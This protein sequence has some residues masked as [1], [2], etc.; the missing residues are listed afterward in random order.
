MVDKIVNFI[1]GIFGASSG[2]MIGKYITV[3]VIS[4]MPILELRGGLIA[5]SLLKVP[6]VPAYIISIIGNLIPIPLI[7]WFLD[8]VFVF[9]KK[10]NILKKFVLFCERK[11]NEK[12][13][14]IEKYGFWGLVLF[15]GVPLPGTGAWTGCLIA[16]MLR[17]NKKKAFLATLLG[18]VMASIIMMLVS[19]GVL[20]NI[21]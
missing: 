18:V 21:F 6:P 7:L 2:A 10:H 13:D 15:V 17:M 16:T 14:S 12:K 3:F 4:L 1:I 19:Y 5:A 20:A 9:M 8:Y 11:G